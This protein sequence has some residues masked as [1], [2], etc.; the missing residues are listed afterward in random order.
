MIVRRAFVHG[1]D[2]P[3]KQSRDNDPEDTIRFYAPRLQ[4][5]GMLKV[6]PRKPIAQDTDWWFVN[7]LTNELGA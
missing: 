4:E 7:E 2:V 5:V 3:W 1:R 6:S